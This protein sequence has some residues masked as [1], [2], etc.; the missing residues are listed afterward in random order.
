MNI[1]LVCRWLYMEDIIS[2]MLTSKTTMTY[3]TGTSFL[4][5]KIYIKDTRELKKIMGSFAG[6][7][8]RKYTK[9]MHM[10]V[11][12][13]ND[14]IITRVG[15][16][17]LE[18]DLG[19]MYVDESYF[20]INTVLAKFDSITID[21]LWI[22][23]NNIVAIEK[24][25]KKIV[26]REV[27]MNNNTLYIYRTM[28]GYIERIKKLDIFEGEEGKS[29]LITSLDF[30]NIAESIEQIEQFDT[31]SE[32]NDHALKYLPKLQ[33]LKCKD[34]LPINRHIPSNIKVIVLAEWSTG[35]SNLLKDFEE[36]W[37]NDNEVKYTRY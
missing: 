34:I 11:Y 35:Y 24:P 22:H 19:R 6:K 15:I 33:K 23:Q 27:H 14:S 29:Y 21:T 18:I 31:C 16:K 30:N 7:L 8:I 3:I 32:I 1:A 9:I 25:K 5:E 26:A 28:I 37:L 4:W 13:F 2:V 20:V 36:L 12:N 17:H 10:D